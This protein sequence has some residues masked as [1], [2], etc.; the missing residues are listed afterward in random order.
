MKART[1]LSLLFAGVVLSTA[2][3]ATPAAAADGCLFNCAK[4]VRTCLKSARMSAATC[5]LDCQA[6]STPDTLDACLADCVTTFRGDR[7]ACLATFPDCATSCEVPPTDPDAVACAQDC[8][9]VLGTCAQGVISAAKTCVAAC[10]GS[11]TPPLQCIGAC[12]Q[13]AR[14]SGATCASDYQTCLTGCGL[15]PP[16]P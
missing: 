7:K 2:A 1:S 8:G 10:P 12:A 14:E 5:R 9:H 3:L 11:G 4:D 6:N 15:T 13:T 16:A